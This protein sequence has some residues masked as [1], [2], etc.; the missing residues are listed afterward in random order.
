MPFLRKRAGSALTCHRHVIHYIPVAVPEKC[1]GAPLTPLHFSTAAQRLLFV[2]SA[3]GSTHKRAPSNPIPLFN[4]IKRHQAKL[5]V[6]IFGARNGICPSADGALVRKNLPQAAFL[7]RTLQIPS[8]FLIRSK[9]IHR[10]YSVYLF[11]LVRGMGFEPTRT[12]VRY[13]LKVVRL[14]VPP[15]SQIL[16]C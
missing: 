6:F 9:K 7:T 3:A 5:D 14:P 4:K 15:S 13:P 8:L 1:F 16:N 12:N 2:S 10:I 11:R